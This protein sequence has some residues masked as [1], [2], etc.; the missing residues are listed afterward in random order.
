MLAAVLLFVAAASAF[1]ILRATVPTPS[2]TISIAGLRGAVVII[3]DKEGVPHIFGKQSYDLCV[4]IGFAHAQDRLWQMEMLRRAGQGRLSE[5][6]GERT[7]NTDIFLRTLDL[8]GHAERSLSAYPQET[9]ALLEAYARGV[10]AF[11]SRDTGILEPQ[12]PPE[13]LLFRHRPE[14]WRPADSVLAVKMMALKLSTNLHHEIDRLSYAAEGLNSAEISE[15]MSKDTDAAPPLPELSEFYPLRRIASI[16]TSS[17]AMAVVESLVGSGA[18]NNWVVSGARTR[19]GKPLLAND[20]HLAVSAPSLWYLAHLAL[21]QPDDST[22]NLVGASLPGTPFIVLGRSDTIAWGF[23]TTGAD[24]QDLFIEKVNPV[25]PSEYLTP[26][27]WRR[28]ETEDMAIHVRGGKT[29][30][31][32]HRKTR[33]GPVL[34]GFFRNLGSLLGEGYVA[35]LQ[36][37]ALSDDDTTL[38]AGMSDPRLR[39]VTEFMERMRLYVVPMQNMV[40]ADTTGSIGFIAPGRVPMRNKANMVAGRA[41]VPGW[42]PKYDWQGFLPFD[43]LPRVKDPPA[44]AIG[45]SNARIVGSDYPHHLTFDWEPP[46]RQQ[47]LK[48]L[49]LDRTDHDIETM[50]SAQTDVLSP[51]VVQLKPLMLANARGA[52]GTDAAVLDRLEAWDATMRADAIE[53][54][55]FMAWV[56][57]TVRAIWSD[58]LGAAFDSFFDTQAA[59]LN[60][61]LEGRALTRDW[62]DNRTTQ[63]RESCQIVVAA[64]LKAALADLERR[65]GSDRARWT[66]GLAHYAYGESRPLGLLPLIGSYFNVEVPSAGGSYTL[67]RGKTEFGEEQPFANRFASSYR[68]IYALADLDRSLYIQSTGQSGNPFSP[69]YRSFAERWAKGEYIRISTNRERIDSTALG[70]WQLEPN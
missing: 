39:H 56:R 65:Y 44:G 50:R 57:E 23:T 8:S 12:L 54:L 31:I 52:G 35:A 60:R 36:W 40:V 59:A 29:R 2:G 27:G 14:P 34:P 7:L 28:F 11:I 58:D 33:H 5:I 43:E 45:T 19:S 16:S 51:A 30:V 26:Q 21:L 3:R 66:W 38:A 63:E 49:V 25:D 13:F 53:P 22:A 20:P 42:D 9:R 46:Y 1:A 41:P 69:F 6:F 4:A 68:A 48:D 15:L 62:C 64:A 67:N 18:S 70:S 24:V 37:T 10:N 55:I 61:V 17:S 47:R 32:E